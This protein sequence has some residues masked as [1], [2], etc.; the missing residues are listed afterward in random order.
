MSL[1]IPGPHAE[2]TVEEISTETLRQS[3]KM[4]AKIRK[5]V[6]IARS[7]PETRLLTR[8]WGFVR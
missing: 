3:P 8:G 6:E 1:S 5:W 7:L 2:P 4:S